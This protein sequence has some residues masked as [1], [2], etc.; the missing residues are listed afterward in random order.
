MIITVAILALTIFLAGA[1]LGVLALLAVGI[2]TGTAAA[3]S[4][5]F[6]ARSLKPSPTGFWASASAATATRT[7]RADTAM[8]DRPAESLP[9]HCTNIR[10]RKCRA[11]VRWY[12]R[13]AWRCHKS[14]IRRL[15]GK[16]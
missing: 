14:P 5:G 3:S 2:W 1:V 10:C 13:K 4:R 8:R 7:R 9:R 12:R 16:K 15:S 11:R 6:R